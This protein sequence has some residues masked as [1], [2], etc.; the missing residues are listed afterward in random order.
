VRGAAAVAVVDGLITNDL[1]RLA[2]GQALYTC[3][4][5]ES[6]GVLDDLI[7]YKAAPE[8]VLVVC[9]A[10][11]RAKIAP[12]VAAA[13][14]GRAEFEDA[15]DRTALIAVQGPRA[16]ELLRGLGLAT[17]TGGAVPRPFHIAAVSL[18]GVP[19]EIARTGYTGEDGVEIVCAAERA[20]ELWRRLIDA[21]QPLAVAAV[22]LA[23]RDT[24]RLE[25][26]LALY[27][28]E[29]DETTHPF[30]AGLGWTVK[31]AGRQ[32]VGKAALVA[33]KERGLAR[34]LVGFEM[35]GRGIARHGYALSSPAGEPLGHCTSG[36][37]SPTLGKN[38][39]LG[40][41]PPAHAALGT[42]LV[43]DC[44]GRTTEARVVETPFYRRPGAGS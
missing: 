13:A 18:A 22:G 12:H 5:N 16:L 24:L 39:G 29:I 43:V 28:N 14:K 32:F 9:N 21:G 41:V 2:P 6:G 30:E 17:G 10:A 37:P 34:K 26:R 33:A 11:N 25:A 1:A 27:G 35:V 36:A 15:S 31:L 8:R 44:R 40:Y 4:C 3:A 7:V 19:C 38:I 23:A 42:T 20:A